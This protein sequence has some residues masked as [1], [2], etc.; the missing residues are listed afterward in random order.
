MPRF[1]ECANCNGTGKETVGLVKMVCKVCKG[2][3][4]VYIY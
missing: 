1:V 4:K 3:G 2:K